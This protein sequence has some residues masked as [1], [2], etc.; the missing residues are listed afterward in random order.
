ME[1]YMY[2][3]YYAHQIWNNYE[4]LRI[5][6]DVVGI[7][8]QNQ[9]RLQSAFKELER[10][11]NEGSWHL[12]RYVVFAKNMRKD[13]AK[14]KKDGRYTRGNNFLH[15]NWKLRG[16]DEPGGVKLP[17]AAIEIFKKSYIS[18]IFKK[19]YFPYATTPESI[20]DDYVDN[21][22]ESKAEENDAKSKADGQKSTYNMDFPPLKLHQLA[23]KL[24]LRF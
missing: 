23:E 2:L 16:A 3:P 9:S 19:S 21:D 14:R 1:R 5:L 11:L 22:A 18:Y 6:K 8:T 24:G 20:W 4:R 12:L 7:D 13:F 10:F 17:A 15:I